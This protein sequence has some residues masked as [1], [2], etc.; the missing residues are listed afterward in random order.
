MQTIDLNDDKEFKEL[1]E[2]FSYFD[3][4]EGEEIRKVYISVVEE[5][6]S[7][8]DCESQS[9]FNTHPALLQYSEEPITDT[10]RTEFQARVNKYSELYLKFWEEYQVSAFVEDENDGE[11]NFFAFDSLDEYKNICL[12][13][14]S[15]EYTDDIGEGVDEED[16]FECLMAQ[17]ENSFLR[18][19]LKNAGAVFLGDYDQTYVIYFLESKFDFDKFSRFVSDAGLFIFDKE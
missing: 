17:D 19:Y 7:D 2:A 5:G 4:Y 12:K 18:L 10:F 13:S 14:A 3:E 1:H 6:F 9:L 15:N 8:E 11:L 16:S